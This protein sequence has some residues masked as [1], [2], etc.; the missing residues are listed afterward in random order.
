[1]NLEQIKSDLNEH[2][3]WSKDI[4]TGNR[5][6]WANKDLEWANLRRAN[7]RGANLEWAN[8]RRANLRG[9]NLEWANLRWA[10]LELANLRGANL[11]STNGI[12]QGPTRLDGFTFYLVQ[13]SGPAKV[14]ASC[15][16]R[17][18][19]EYRA[20]KPNDETLRILAYLETEAKARGW[21]DAA[22]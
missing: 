20:T 11:A 2:A 21:S 22:L 1:M 9:A 13:Q 5:I 10:N 15:R 8:L 19:E 16:W 17:T 6:D 3:K 18:I 7:L 12:I 4:N 14:L